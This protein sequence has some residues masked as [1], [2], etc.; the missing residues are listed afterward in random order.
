M[1]SHPHQTLCM[2]LHFS[3]HIFTCMNILRRFYFLTPWT[4][5]HS[6][7]GKFGQRQMKRNG[8]SETGGATP[9]KIDLQVFHVNLYM[10]EFL[11]QFYFLTPMDYTTIVHG[12]NGK[13][14]PFLKTNKGAITPKLEGPHSLKLVCMHLISTPT[15]MNFLSRF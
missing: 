15:C 14:W 5:V 8:I 9:T 3:L 10:H 7:K 11:S 4:I 6:L 2:R 13:F 1:R 12:P